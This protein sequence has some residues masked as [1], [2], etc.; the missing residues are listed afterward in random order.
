MNPDDKSAVRE[1]AATFHETRNEGLGILKEMNE[2]NQR[3][4]ES[5]RELGDI[6]RKP[7]PPVTWRR[8][9]W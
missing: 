6:L 1:A 4:S 3:L 5:L 2:V 9:R 8:V 7:V